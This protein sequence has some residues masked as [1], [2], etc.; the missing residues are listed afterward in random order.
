[1]GQRLNI[2]ITK[3]D[4][5][6]AN[7]YYHWS[8]YTSSALELINIIVGFYNS[9][10][11]EFDSYDDLFKASVLLLSTGAGFTKE[12]Y[13]YIINY[14][15]NFNNVFKSIDTKYLF[16]ATSRDDGLIG[17]TEHEINETRNWEEARVSFDLDSLTIDFNALF[18]SSIEEYKNDYCCDDEDDINL[19]N[20]D[21]DV[22]IHSIP[23]SRFPEFYNKMKEYLK[24]DLG[25]IIKKDN[26][27]E[28]YIFIE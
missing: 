15:N 23:I 6:I 16:M 13:E 4:K 8:G 12:S 18:Y 5:V 20:F 21:L 7:A 14:S 17:L 3:G 2:E 1:M 26:K 22:D 24:D 28:V 10:C 25:F 19:K 11:K 27:E 9:K